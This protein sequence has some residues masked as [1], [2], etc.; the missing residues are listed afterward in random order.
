MIVVAVISE[1]FLAGDFSVYK[2]KRSSESNSYT[3]SSSRK[4]LFKWSLIVT[5]LEND[6]KSEIKQN[7]H[8][9]GLAGLFKTQF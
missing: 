6:E 1:C 5:E 9:L 4:I 3:F 2:T 7:M 8:Q